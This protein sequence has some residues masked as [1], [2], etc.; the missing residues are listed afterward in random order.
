MFRS[1]VIDPVRLDRLQLTW[2]EDYGGGVHPKPIVRSPSMFTVNEGEIALYRPFNQNW[3][4]GAGMTA[5]I[6]QRDPGIGSA[7]LMKR[8]SQPRRQQSDMQSDR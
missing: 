5:A 7:R 6:S 3:A 8:S 2:F 1:Y 4:I